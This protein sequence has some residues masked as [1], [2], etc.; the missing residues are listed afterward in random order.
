[1]GRN[2]YRFAPEYAPAANAS[3]SICLLEVK[4]KRGCVPPFTVREFPQDV[5]MPVQ[6]EAC[7]RACICHAPRSPNVAEWHPTYDEFQAR[8]ERVE[9]TISVTDGELA[10]CHAEFREVG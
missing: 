7:T 8:S 9:W 2:R 5:A 1:M 3:V 10:L 6:H 4:Q